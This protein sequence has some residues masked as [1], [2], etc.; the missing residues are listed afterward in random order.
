MTNVPA[1]LFYTADHEWVRQ[2]EGSVA[3]VG[4]TEF[5]TLALGDVTFLDLPSV[6]DGV[7]A[8]SQCGEI[9]STKS[10]SPLYAPV[11]GTVSAVNDAVLDVP[12]LVNQDPFGQGW[13]FE[14]NPTTHGGLLDAEAYAA[15][16]AIEDHPG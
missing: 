11:S 14:V 3:R 9:E 16:I 15:L 2:P 6:G 12:E 8:G 1:D 7:E 13:L 4:V 10:V 5:A